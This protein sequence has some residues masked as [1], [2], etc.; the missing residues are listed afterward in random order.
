M[1]DQQLIHICLF[2]YHLILVYLVV[3]RND[4]KRLDDLILDL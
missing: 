4:L 1:F 2:Y 3:V